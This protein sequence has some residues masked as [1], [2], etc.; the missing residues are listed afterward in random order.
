MMEWKKKIKIKIKIKQT[1]KMSTRD[2]DARAQASHCSGR[3]NLFRLI[4]DGE[5]E[6]QDPDVL[7][8]YSQK[9][10]SAGRGRAVALLSIDPIDGGHRYLIVALVQM[11]TCAFDVLEDEPCSLAA[12]GAMLVHR[13]RAWVR[14]WVRAS[15]RDNPCLRAGMWSR[16]RRG[17]V[18][19]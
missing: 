17:V 13:V 5:L 6:P 14:E 11:N 18:D 7:A 10:A 8:R 16:E 19:L 15:C 2:R 1:N 12:R 9:Y 3:Y 4:T